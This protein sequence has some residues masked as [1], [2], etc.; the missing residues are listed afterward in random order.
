MSY[1]RLRSRLFWT[2]RLLECVVLAG[3][4]WLLRVRLVVRVL[5]LCST[6]ICLSSF[7]LF[8]FDYFYGVGVHVDLFV[9]SYTSTRRLIL[10]L[11]FITVWVLY[12]LRWDPSLFNG[13]VITLSHSGIIVEAV[14]LN[15]KTVYG[16]PVAWTLVPLEEMCPG[17]LFFSS[18]LL[19]QSPHQNPE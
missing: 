10:P 4:Y 9:Y 6:S 17:L 12:L 15:G 8:E 11:D 1:I 19:P 14:N 5:G 7:F 16:T 2:T 3:F 18:L 13:T